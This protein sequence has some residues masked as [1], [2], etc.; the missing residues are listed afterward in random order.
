MGSFSGWSV[1][2]KMGVK[3]GDILRAV[4][5]VDVLAMA[6]DSN[7]NHPAMDLLK[8][9]YGTKC[10]LHLMRVDVSQVKDMMNRPAATGNRSHSVTTASPTRRRPS[11]Q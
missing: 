10:A 6:A 5:G 7:G 1:A 8:G 9:K 2:D 3:H 11:R 4:D